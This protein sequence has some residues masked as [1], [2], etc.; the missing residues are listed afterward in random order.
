MRTAPKRQMQSIPRPHSIDSDLMRFG[1]HKPVVLHADWLPS[2]LYCEPTVAVCLCHVFH[3]MSLC[4]QN[5]G[6]RRPH[7]GASVTP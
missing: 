6:A 7:S 5:L 4:R 2:R 1:Q 3:D